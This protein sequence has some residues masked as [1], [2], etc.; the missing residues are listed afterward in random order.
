M[1]LRSALSQGLRKAIEEF[2]ERLGQMGLTCRRLSTSHAF[3]SHLM[4]SIADGFVERVKRVSLKPPQIPY[5]SNVT[6]T[7]MTPDD[8]QNP[9]YWA[10]QLRQP[11][12]LTMDSASC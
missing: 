5:V 1:D 2:E 8:A 3:H 11:C 4:E 10:R 9:Q 12:A 6:G 7:W